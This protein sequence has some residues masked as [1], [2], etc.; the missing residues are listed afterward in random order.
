MDQDK[1]TASPSEKFSRA[2]TE[3]LHEF[4][5][6]EGLSAGLVMTEWVIIAAAQGWDDEGDE[7][8]QVV[9][10]PHGTDTRVLGLVEHARQRMHSDIANTYAPM[11]RFGGDDDVDED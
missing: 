5:D 6:A 9:V 3:A 2:L 7:I 10:E 1:P 8:S 4:A 11:L